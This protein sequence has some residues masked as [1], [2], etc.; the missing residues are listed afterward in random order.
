MQKRRSF[1]FQKPALILG[2]S[3]ALATLGTAVLTT[4]L[5]AQGGAIP[6]DLLDEADQ[7]QALCRLVDPLSQTPV[8]VT[9]SNASESEL[10]AAKELAEHLSKITGRQIET[11]AESGV[12]Q[13]RK[14]IA[15][16][17]SKLTQSY[18]TSALGIEQYIIDTKPTGVVIIGGRKEPVKGPD[19]DLLARDRGTL[20]GVYAFLE[21]LGVRWYRPEPWSWHIPRKE[22]IELPVKRQTSAAPAFVARTATRLYKDIIDIK[23]DTLALTEQWNARQR[24]NLRFVEDKRFGGQLR[25]NANWHTHTG[26]IVTPAKYLKKN[27]EYFALVDGKR[28]NPGSGRLPQL[29]LGNPELQ[30]VFAANIIDLAR[31]NPHWYMVPIDPEDGT[32]PARRMCAC[33]LC[34]AM[35]D[36]AVPEN[37]TNRVFGFANIVA[38]KVAQD[39]PDLKLALYAYSSHTNL[40]TKIDR[41]EPN[42]IVGLA[43]INS[44]SDWSKKLTDPDNVPNAGFLQLAEGWRKISV[45]KLWMRDY[46]AYGWNGPIPMYRLLQDRVQT[47]RKLGFEAIVWP[48]EANWG[49]QQLLIYFKLQL[50]WNPDLDLEKELDSFYTNYYGPAAKPMKAFHE[51]WMTTFEQSQLGSGLSTGISSGGR[52]M[53]ALCTPALVS[54]LGGY[55]AEAKKLTAGQELYEKRLEGDLTSHEMISRISK[56]ITLKLTQGTPTSN[57]RTGTTYM[58]SDAAEKEWDE[59]VAWLTQA[60]K[61]S[62]NFEVKPDKNNRLATA[63][64]YM[65]RDILENGR[66]SPWDEAPLLK[67]QGFSAP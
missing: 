58:K 29:C 38:R 7:L 16:G 36:P 44:W 26:L 13:G 32:Q 3:L 33:D 54:E 57:P 66:Y 28:G 35:D 37:M 50:Q 42:I 8:I 6:E 39:L 64:L 25:S 21:S 41:L 48:T 52:G 20:Y 1:L 14:F 67:A 5:A 2:F 22:T 46:S 17:R 23:P 53:H 10:Y 18:D 15:V 40:P 56:I 60:N 45:H 51:K 34:K 31:K 11:V 30:N 63:L 65:K 19:G 55:L 4:P 47:Y 27:P 61:N 12:P 59:F 24:A 43:N 49:P 62:I 9:G